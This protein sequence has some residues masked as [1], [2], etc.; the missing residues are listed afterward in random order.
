MS[1][2]AA[3]GGIPGV[4][5]EVGVL[6]PLDVGVAGFS[7]CSLVFSEGVERADDDPECDGGRSPRS[8]LAP[9]APSKELDAPE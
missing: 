5:D 2:L 1:G 6:P 7:E 3:P 8:T 4:D 9:E